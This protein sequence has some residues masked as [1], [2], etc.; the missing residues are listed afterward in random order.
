VL[1]NTPGQGGTNWFPP[2]FDPETGL[3]YVNAVKG[4]SLAYLTNTDERPEG[5]GGNGRT[6]W[7]QSVLKAIDYKTGQVRWVH[8]F[9]GKG[10]AG[11]G[12]LRTAGKLLFSGDPSGK[13][14][15]DPATGKVLSHFRLPAPV[16]NGPMTYEL[17][18][19]QYLVA[20]AGDTLYSFALVK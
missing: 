2:S 16:S 3:F 18:G 10:T 17:D 5:Y 9:P 7:S 6:L 8:E 15:W 11:S 19:R 1:P 4:Y 20:A 13:I 12:L 14:A